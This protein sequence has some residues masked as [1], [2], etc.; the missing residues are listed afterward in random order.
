LFTDRLVVDELRLEGGDVWEV[1]GEALG[2]GTTTLGAG[3]GAFG[4]SRLKGILNREEFMRS[5]CGERR[6]LRRKKRERR[7]RG[8]EGRERQG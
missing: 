4:F 1:V 8:E 7:G 3:D 6:S 2:G 5:I